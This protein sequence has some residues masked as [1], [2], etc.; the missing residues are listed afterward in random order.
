MIQL[1][2][3]LR[4]WFDI[5]SGFLSC[6]GIHRDRPQLLFSAAHL[7]VTVTKG[8]FFDYGTA[9]ARSPTPIPGYVVFLHEALLLGY[10]VT[11]YDFPLDW[12]PA[13]DFSISSHQTRHSPKA[14][15][16]CVAMRVRRSLSPT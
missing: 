7:I 3:W 15:I 13:S 6:E 12:A 2:D 10:F 4:V 14:S 16:T 5:K 1:S 8:N 9:F 11:V